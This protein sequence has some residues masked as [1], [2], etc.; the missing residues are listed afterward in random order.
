[1]RVNEAFKEAKKTQTK[2][3]IPYITCGDP[4]TSFTKDLVKDLVKIG[5]D[6]IELGVPFSDPLADGPI[7]QRAAQ[8][9]LKN[10]INIKD[11]CQ[12]VQSLRD[13]SVTIPIILFTYF[14]PIFKFGLD[15]FI[16][17]AKN[18]KIDAVLIVDL[19]FEEAQLV[20]KKLLDNKIGIIQLISPTTSKERLA[21]IYKTNPEF[22]YYISR[23]GVTGVG[24]KLSQSL[25]AEIKNLKNN[26]D[27]PI[28]VGFGISNPM[29]AKEVAG[30]ADGVIVGSALVK[31]LENEDLIEAREK[32]C[33]LAKDLNEAI[34]TC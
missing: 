2:L 24:N 15:N 25:I 19:P 21:K 12:L 34:K 32:L 5:A 3:F 22:L 1:M 30:F 28:A 33:K 27:I 23:T 14:N 17:F 26:T 11:C 20:H 16:D 10:E 7:N 4:N 18:A 31:E 9:A 8:R 13:D 6:I 29:Q